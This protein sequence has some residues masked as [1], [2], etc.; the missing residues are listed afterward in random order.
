MADFLDRCL[1]VEPDERASAE[2]LLKHPFLNLTKP[3]RCLHALIEAARRN[4]GKPV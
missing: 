1:T 4:L 3:L 2:E